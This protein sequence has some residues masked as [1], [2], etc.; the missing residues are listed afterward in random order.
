MRFVLLCFITCL[1]ATSFAASDTV[2]WLMQEQRDDGSW[3][4]PNIDLPS[5]FGVNQRDAPSLVTAQVLLAL[6]ID[7]PAHDKD[8]RAVAINQGARFLISR[9]QENGA[10]G[11]NAWAHPPALWALCEVYA[12]RLEDPIHGEICTVLRP[13]I[14]KAL[15]YSQ[16]QQVTHPTRKHILLGWCADPEQTTR[17]RRARHHLALPRSLCCA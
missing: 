4:H 8:E 6:L 10:L 11:D 5:P 9:A 14:E 7:G 1:C 2:R 16:R 12:R 17:L 15:I 3:P 13:V